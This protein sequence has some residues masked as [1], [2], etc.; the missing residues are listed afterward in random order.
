MWY[1]CGVWVKEAVKVGKDQILEYQKTMKTDGRVLWHTASMSQLCS[2]RSLH[3][4]P[5]STCP[6]YTLPTWLP[7]PLSHP[8]RDPVQTSLPL[9]F[10]IPRPRPKARELLSLLRCLS[11]NCSLCTGLSRVSGR[12]QAWV[13]RRSGLLTW[14]CSSCWCELTFVLNSWFSIHRK[15]WCFSL[16]FFLGGSGMEPGSIPCFVWFLQRQYCWEILSESVRV[17]L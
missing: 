4:W 12:G 11:H 6:K 8:P 5:Q 13:C 17:I 7:L 3:S 2:K 1:L 15:H 14:F 10:C 16:S 9:K